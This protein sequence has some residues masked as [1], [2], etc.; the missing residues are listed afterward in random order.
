MVVPRYLLKKFN[1]HFEIEKKQVDRRAPMEEV[2]PSAVGEERER[3][4]EP[5][6]P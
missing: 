5:A 2:V 6:L 3:G 4:Q 1:A